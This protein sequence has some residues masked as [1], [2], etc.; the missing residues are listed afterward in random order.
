[1]FSAMIFIPSASTIT[2]TFAFSRTA[3]TTALVSSFTPRPQPITIPS[4]LS[5]EE[6]SL[7]RQ[8]ALRVPHLFP[9]EA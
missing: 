8:S 7:G 5:S 9:E 6:I 4:Y 3:F 1:M 2:G